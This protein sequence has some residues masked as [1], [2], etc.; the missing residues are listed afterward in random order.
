MIERKKLNLNQELFI[1]VSI[2]HILLS[3]LLVP[4]SSFLFNKTIEFNFELFL[5]KTLLII[6]FT[7]ILIVLY[8][9]N[10]IFKK[11]YLSIIYLTV[12]IMYFLSIFF[13]LYL[14]RA[15]LI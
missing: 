12:L 7:I 4:I 14:N 15:F 11:K 10:T 8:K 13:V 6:S 2:L 1:E 3:Y 5:Y 9:L